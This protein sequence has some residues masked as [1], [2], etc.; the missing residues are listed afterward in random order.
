MKFKFDSS[1]CLPRYKTIEI[2]NAT[3]VVRV[4][5]YENNKYYP[6]VF[7]DECYFMIEFKFL[8]ELMLIRQ[9]NQKSV[10]FVTIVVFFYIKA[11]NFNQLSP[12]DVMIY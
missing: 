5:F 8:K 9:A 1:D 4:A 7:L 10:I 12:V 11:L 3:I 6:Q 2:H